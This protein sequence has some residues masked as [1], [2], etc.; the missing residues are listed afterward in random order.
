MI[1]DTP[2]D[3]IGR[4]ERH[5]R[6]IRQAQDRHDAHRDDGETALT[7]MHAVRARNAALWPDCAAAATPLPATEG[8]DE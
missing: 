1:R 7:A 6:M 3:A 4:R 5:N 8:G 2:E